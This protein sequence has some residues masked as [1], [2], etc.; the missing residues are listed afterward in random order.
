MKTF[1]PRID[2]RTVPRGRMLEQLGKRRPD[3]SIVALAGSWPACAA[4]V[5]AAAS[6]N[7]G[8][9]IILACDGGAGDLPP[10]ITAIHRENNETAI[11]L[12]NRAGALALGRLICILRP[13]EKGTARLSDL[14]DSFARDPQLGALA[15]GAG[16]TNGVMARESL[17]TALAGLEP[18]FAEW[19]WA[20]HD[21][22]QRARAIGFAA[23]AG[24][25]PRDAG[26]ADVALFRYR[27]SLAPARS[28]ISRSGVAAD[29]R[30]TLYTAITNGYDTLKPQP[31]ESLGGIEPVAFLDEPTAEIYQGRS[32][33]WRVTAM[34]PSDRD[35][36]RAAR[37]PKINAHL[38]LPY[39]DY[40]L[41]IDASIGIVSPFPLAH[42]ADLFLQDRD[43]CL[44]RHY[45]R[46]SI[47]EE[48]EAC[49]AYGLDRPNV[50][51]AQMA[52]YRAE[53][54]PDDTGL[55]EA[56][57]ILR[58]HTDAIRRLNEAW[59][60]EIV[61]GSRRDQLSFNYV[62]WKLGLRYATFPLSL[63]TGNG[64]FVKFQRRQR[65]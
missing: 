16:A 4:D 61:R 14:A 47:F 12:V 18:A 49:K 36:H 3:V 53:G 62:A 46:G 41:W 52:R 33:G 20:M 65:P 54:L 43:I 24:T 19:D 7:P 5:E 44:F 45:A 28:A 37:F 6:G 23:P 34:P 39:S 42:L 22:C 9:Q 1:P 60:G 59:W 40:T 29:S 56:P 2:P 25:L 50:I 10:G 51:D 13:G 48:A 26:G 30:F 21:F 63:A 17:W 15:F 32:R 55:I 57:V 35:P 27:A 38:A 58:R 64:L 31:A 11:E 8:Y